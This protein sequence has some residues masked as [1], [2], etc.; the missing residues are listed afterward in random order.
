MPKI[1]TKLCLAS[2]A[3]I[4]RP[5]VTSPHPKLL[6]VKLSKASTLPELLSLHETCGDHFNGL[7][8]S[9][10]WSKFKKLPRGK[11]DGLRDRLEPVCEQTI[12]MLPALIDAR[13][14]ANVAH[15]F[16]KARLTVGTGPW[17]NVWAALPKAVLR[18]LGGFDEQN[19]SNTAWAFAKAGHSSAA[20]FRAISAEA[21]R[22]GLGRFNEQALSNTAWAFAKADHSSPALFRAISAEALRRG[23]G[24]FIEQALSNTAWA[25]AKAG[26]SSP[27]LFSAISAEA[28]RRGLGGFDERALSNAAWAFAKVGHASSALF[29]AISEP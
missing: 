21:L 18:L 11:L 22:R 10:F 25:F 7:H 4:L 29:G 1:S 3:A 19:L 28:L 13:A 8:I 12:R 9:A 2:S 27:A 16:A 17:H 14:V 5:N 26:L 15:A 23:L 24:G 20:L 6:T